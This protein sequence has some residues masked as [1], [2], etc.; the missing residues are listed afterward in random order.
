MFKEKNNNTTDEK[1]K[2]SDTKTPRITDYASQKTSAS[3]IHITDSSDDIIVSLANSYENKQ[4]RQVIEWET[5]QRK[6]F[7]KTA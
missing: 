2:F 6:A 4:A 7:Y 5:M 1:R 3:K